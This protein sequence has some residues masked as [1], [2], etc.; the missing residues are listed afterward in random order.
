[1]RRW[2]VVVVVSFLLALAAGLVWGVY[3]DDIRLALALRKCSSVWE[4]LHDYESDFRVDVKLGP[5]N[6]SVSGTV[7]YLRPHAYK[8]ELGDRTRPGCIVVKRTQTAFV[9][10]PDAKVAVDVEF[11]RESEGDAV[12]ASQSPAPWVKQLGEGSKFRW[13]GK[14]EVSGRPCSVLELVPPQESAE[15]GGSIAAPALG[16]QFA[17][18]PFVGSWKRTRVSLDRNTGLPIRGEALKSDGAVLFSWTASNVRTN[19]GLSAG[20]FELDARGV[21]VVKRTYDPVHPERLFVPPGKGRSLLRQLGDAL[22]EGAKEYLE[23]QTG[24]G[25]SRSLGGHVIEK[26]TH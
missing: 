8:L 19:R 23:G 14:G 7:S 18:I 25:S 2:P 15:S 13:V 12:L 10:F 17:G 6:P 16:K 5:L 22:E 11:R 3:G 1:M 21:R 9:W 4:K 26:L 24:D 20:D